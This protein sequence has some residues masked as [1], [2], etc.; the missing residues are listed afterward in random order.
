MANE[1]ATGEAILQ[2]VVRLGRALQASGS[3][4][5]LSEIIDATT[6]VSL[7][8]LGD[9]Q[10]LRTALQSTLV[11]QARSLDQFDRAFDR[12]FPPRPRSSH[13]SEG[14]GW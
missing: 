10:Q 5:A 6:A 4:V 12:L 2:Q 9:R 11:K 8:D 14:D 1:T 13:A 7:I 3:S